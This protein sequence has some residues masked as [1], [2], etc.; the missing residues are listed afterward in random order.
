MAYYTFMPKDAKFDR[1][2]QLALKITRNDTTPVDKIIAIRD[3][4]LSKDDNGKPLFS[5]TDNPGVPDIPNASKLQYFLFENHKGYCAYYAGAT[6]FLLRAL[7]IPS[8]I[9]VGFMTVD[10]SNKNKGWYWY[11]ADQAHAWVQVYFPGFG[12]LDFDTTVGNSDAR[13]SPKP[14]GTPPMQPPKAYFAGNGIVTKV[15]TINKLVDFKMY[16]LVYHD[17]EDSLQTLVPLHLDVSIASIKRDSTFLSLDQLNT[18]DSITAVSYAEAFR[19]LQR[20]SHE[21]TQKLI[22]RF[23]SPAPIDEIHVKTHYKEQQEKLPSKHNTVQN[24]KWENILLAS[25]ISIGFLILL[26][27]ALP[28]LVL[29]YYKIRYAGS[30]TLSQKAYWAYR[31]AGFYIHQLGFFK[32]GKTPLQHARSVDAALET[33]FGEFMLPYL[34]LK[35]AQ[36]KLNAGEEQI[37]LRF[38][39]AFLRSVK[40]KVPFGRRFK[41]F[42]RTFR[43]IGFFSLEQ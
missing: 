36:Q 25:L 21:S 41:D 24:G 16:R 3:Y 15:D 2:R 8:R 28:R 12:W 23:P 7:G 32:A 4:F 22:N 13:E 11:Y 30:G 37:L 1:I 33:N 35:Y 19:K 14:D 31:T 6:L 43:A 9:T 38:L 29:L 10:R 20:R 42:F 26:F 34:K 39:P 40:K 17:R 27:L 18:G 5:Y